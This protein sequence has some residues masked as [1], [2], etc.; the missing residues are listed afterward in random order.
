SGPNTATITNGGT[1]TPTM[2]NLVAGSYV[3]Q[4]TIANSSGTTTSDQMTLK[5]NPATVFTV[6]AGP[7][8]TITLPTNS[9][10]LT[11]TATVQGTTLASSTWKQIS[12][13]NTAT[14][15]NGGTITPTMS[16]LIAGSYV[17]QV[18]I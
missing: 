7:D 9:A 15:T 16:G 10:K 8:V 12:G 2:S 1:I 5:V 4:V 3:F 18:T 6:S 14:I 13:P 17:F 11:G